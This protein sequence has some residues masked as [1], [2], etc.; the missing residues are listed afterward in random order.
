MYRL[1][2]RVRC[3]RNLRRLLQVKRQLQIPDQT[4]NP[5]SSPA[6]RRWGPEDRHRRQAG[7]LQ[8]E[9]ARLGLLLRLLIL[10]FKRDSPD[11]TNRDLGAGRTQAMRSGSSGRDAARAPQGHGCPF[12]AGPRSIA[13]VREPRRRRGL[14]GSKH[15]WLL[16]VFSS[17]PPK[18]ERFCR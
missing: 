8:E 11:T 12:G 7:L 14:T 5:C 18:A 4:Q 15:P 6:C 17:N 13:G 16:G 10:I 9:R 2:D 1:T 3:R